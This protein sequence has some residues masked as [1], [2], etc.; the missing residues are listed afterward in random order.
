[1]K[2]SQLCRELRRAGCILTQH[3]AEHDE[4]MNPYTGVKIRIPRHGSREVKKGLL[5]RIQKALLGQ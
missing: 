3:G 5:I 2:T 1:M 4:W